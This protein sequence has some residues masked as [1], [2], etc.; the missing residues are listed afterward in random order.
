MGQDSALEVAPE[1]LFNMIRYAVAHGV[2]LIGQGEVGLQ[3]LPDDAVEGGG[4]GTAPTIG[5]GMGAGRWSGWLCGPPGLPASRVGL[6]RHQRPP[7][8]RGVELGVP[9]SRTAEGWGGGM[10]GKGPGPA[11]GGKVLSGPA[12][13]GRL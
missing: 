10:V 4:L 2:G 1:S 13:G 9:T 12:R 11:T 7:G 6:N 3:V 5:L 8:S